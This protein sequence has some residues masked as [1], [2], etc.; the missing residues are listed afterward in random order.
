VFLISVEG[1]FDAAHHLPGYDGKCANVHGHR[2]RVSVMYRWFG[3]TPA[4]GISVDLSRAKHQLKTTLKSFD[5]QDLNTLLDF[6]SAELLAKVIFQELAEDE[7]YKSEMLYSVAIEESP[8]CIVTYVP[9][10]TNTN[11]LPN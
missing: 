7:M 9:E 6:P 4:S 2:W 11:G 10:D 5:H 1:A 3:P 8:G